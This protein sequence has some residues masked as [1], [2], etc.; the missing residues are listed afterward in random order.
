MTGEELLIADSAERDREGLRKLFDDLGF[1]C[2]ACSDVDTAKELVRR[3]F[4]PAALIDV[5]FGATNGGLELARFVQETSRPT[6]IVLLTSRRSYEAAV[7]ALRIGVVDVISKRPDQLAHLQSTMQRA[8]D[9]YRSGDKGSALMSE[10]NGVLEESLRIM[11]SMARKVYRT[12]DSSGGGL[13][14]KPAILIIDEDQRF[15]KQLSGALGDKGWDVSVEL[16]GG[17][18]LDRASTFNFQ[19]VAAR[20]QLSDLPGDMLLRSAQAHQSQ[21]LSLLYSTEGAGKIERHEAG[22]VTKTWPYAGPESLVRCMDELVGEL[23]QRREERRYMQGFRTEHGAFLKRVAE[24][25]ARIEQ[26]AG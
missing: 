12:S 13:A 23:N 7:E 17:S 25:K 15:L 3:K 26:L 19:I 1:V 8:F 24:L 22:R 14:V 9:L 16:S 10:V 11:V 2:T 20:E 6:R 21:L 4:F 5:D 18:G